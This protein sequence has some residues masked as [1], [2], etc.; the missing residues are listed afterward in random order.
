MTLKNRTLEN[1]GN[2]KITFQERQSCINCGLSSLEN[3]WQGHFSEQ[4]TRSFLEK[5]HYNGNILELLG[6]DQF[7]LVKCQECGMMFHKTILSSEW[8]NVLYSQWIDDSQ[9][10]NF[11]AKNQ[12]NGSR[13]AK[14]EQGR[15][16]TKHVLRLQKLLHKNSSQPCRILDY[17]CGD[18][19]FL[20]LA[21]LFGFEGYGLDFS[22]T[23]ARRAGRSDITIVNSLEE[24]DAQ[25]V[26]KFHAVSLFQV[27]EHLP[28][29]IAVLRKLANRMEKGGILIV[30]VPD[31]RG[32]SKPDN[33]LEFHAVQP[34][35]HINAFTPITLKQMCER[36]GFVSI[37]R[38]AAHVTTNFV[39]IL[40]TEVSRIV[41]PLRTQQ[42][43]RL[44][45]VPTLEF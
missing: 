9:I 25:Q 37:P 3:I 38:P 17:G 19:N 7:S 40:R 8:L 43:F 42:Y 13:E 44:H 30:E 32:I 5:F 1:Q 24:F 36:V 28:D 15:Q 16:L 39:D 22:S 45:H 35:E 31:C 34:L 21:V 27:L 10:E 18:G 33:F 2:D 29:P 41:H 26:G 23:R 11:E 12:N 4:L 6:D 20:N 14:F